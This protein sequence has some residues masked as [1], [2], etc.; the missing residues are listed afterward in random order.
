MKAFLKGFTYAFRGVGYCFKH[1]RNFRFHISLFSYM[2]FFLLYYDFFTVSKTQWA[3]LLMM[4][5]AVIS[6]ELINT[7]IE[8]A[9]DAVTLN[10]NK[11]IKAA[12]DAAAGAVLV[13][14]VFSVAV[15]ICILYQPEA[16]E[17]LF[18]YYRA[19]PLYFVILL[20]TLCAD[21]VFIFYDS[22]FKKRK[23]K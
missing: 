7:G 18:S 10:H 4:S 11:F 3:V 9:A 8:K 13:T 15:G 1:E 16:F 22:I 19:N 12:K 17:K 21:A 2:L 20:I 14:A 23:R 5:S 6:G